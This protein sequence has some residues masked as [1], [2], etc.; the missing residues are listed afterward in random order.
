MDDSTAQNMKP[1]SSLALR[2]KIEVNLTPGGPPLLDIA[3]MDSIGSCSIGPDYTAD[4]DQSNK[5]NNTRPLSN[6]SLRSVALSA[7]DQNS[8][9][10]YTNGTHV[11]S[12]VGISCA[13]SG[14]SS[15]SRYSASA[16]ASLSRGSSPTVKVVAAGNPAAFAGATP[17]MKLLDKPVGV[18]PL[19]NNGLE[20]ASTPRDGETNCETLGSAKSLVQQRIESLYGSE[21]AVGWRESRSKLKTPIANSTS[22][23]K[24]KHRSPSC[25]PQRLATCPPFDASKSKQ[26]QLLIEI[27]QCAKTYLLSL[28]HVNRKCA[29]FPSY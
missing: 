21:A 12:Y 17:V 8:D 6:I 24:E 19:A 5:T 25:P 2:N 9:D 18:T 13:I 7:G 29:R 10:T 16:R 27:F 3:S 26:L 15:Y 23:G 28:C 20:L 4:F 11:P 14:Y 1:P 22:S